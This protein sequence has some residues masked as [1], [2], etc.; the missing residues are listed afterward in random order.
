MLNINLSIFLNSIFSIFLNII[1]SIFLNI[2]QD[3]I[4]D[5][6]LNVTLNV[7]MNIIPI[8]IFSKF[9][10]LQYLPLCTFR[11]GF[12]FLKTVKLYSYLGV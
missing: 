3:F 8:S 5:I 4:L 1:L 9:T 6:I 10:I 7:I 2:L 11:V 12:I